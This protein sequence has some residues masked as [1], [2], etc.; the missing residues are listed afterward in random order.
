MIVELAVSGEGS[1]EYVKDLLDIVQ[2]PNVEPVRPHALPW[3]KCGCCVSM[4]D[5]D[6]NKCCGRKICITSYYMFK[7]LCLDRDVLKF[8]IRA[9]CDIRA[10]GMDF[11]MN[12]FRKASYRQFALWKYGHLGKSNRRVLPSCVVTV[13]RNLYPSSDGRYMG[14]KHS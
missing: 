11:S 2:N 1:L 13:I 6:H 4:K 3:C 12:A 8:N 9:R 7:K 14:F 10:E 5:P